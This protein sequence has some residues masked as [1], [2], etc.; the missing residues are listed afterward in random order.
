[1]KRTVDF[2]ISTPVFLSPFIR[3]IR[4]IR[5][6]FFINGVNGKVVFY[7]AYKK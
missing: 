3:V 1:M 7:P 6:S 2:V 4:A 5:G